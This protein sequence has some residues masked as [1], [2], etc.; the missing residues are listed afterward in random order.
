MATHLKG[1]RTKRRKKGKSKIVTILLI[2][3]II[4]AI[5]YLAAIY[6]SSFDTEVESNTENTQI[7]NVE[8]ITQNTVVENKVKVDDKIVSNVT[9]PAKIG[10]YEVEGKLVIDKIGV[11]LNILS[12]YTMAAMDVSI[13]HYYGPKINEPGNFC[14]IGHDYW[15][16]LAKLP[17]LKKG[18]TFYMIS[19][20]TKKQVDY[21][22]ERV[23]QIKPDDFSCL[24][25]NNDGKREV[26]IIT[27]A[28][29][30]AKRI[31]CKARET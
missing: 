3:I 23:Y 1:K 14:I 4:I 13:T 18:D 2:L 30:G 12:K 31:V 24:E 16:M 15:N 25:Q 21:K 8:K 17:N 19:R 7:S 28:P 5:I 9:I 10:D 26:T 22:V 11:D 20:E 6:S 29:G 27:C